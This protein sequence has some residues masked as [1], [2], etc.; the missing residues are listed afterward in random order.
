M[1]RNETNFWT[2][3]PVEQEILTRLKQF[4]T[5]D[6]KFW[7]R[8]RESTIGVNYW[9]IENPKGPQ[10]TSELRSMDETDLQFLAYHIYSCCIRPTRINI[11]E[12]VWIIVKT[13]TRKYKVYYRTVK[14]IILREDNRV[15]A[16]LEN[17]DDVEFEYDRTLYENK[18]LAERMAKVYELTGEDV[19]WEKHI[20][21]DKKKESSPP[22]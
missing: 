13:Q 3:T 2:G 14:E 8:K 19:P 16:K 20:K 6:R 1:K 22:F 9:R 15:F 12:N 17:C 7:Y 10:K 11:G 4:F 5:L 21:K 18:A